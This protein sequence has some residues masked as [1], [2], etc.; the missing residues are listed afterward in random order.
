MWVP[1]DLPCRFHCHSGK[2][3]F[4]SDWLCVARFGQQEM[5]PARETWSQ[6]NRG[7]RR[8]LCYT[9]VAEGRGGR[10]Q[11]FLSPWV[12]YDL[13]SQFT[14]P[15]ELAGNTDKEG[16]RAPSWSCDLCWEISD[17]ALF[18]L[19]KWKLI[20]TLNTTLLSLL[21][22]KLQML[23]LELHYFSSLQLPPQPSG[24]NL[25]Q[26]TALSQAPSLSP[27]HQQITS[28][29]RLDSGG[30]REEEFPWPHCRHYNTCKHRQGLRHRWA[31]KA[32]RNL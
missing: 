14:R 22:G 18:Q 2:G 17:S 5:M 13:P 1:Y 4:H 32:K 8:G 23:L 29:L 20:N 27:P 3:L 30:Q 12:T 21:L 7:T 24:Q 6:E 26:L 31:A 19:R 25:H 15:Q 16:N 11:I 10:S 9:R 28:H